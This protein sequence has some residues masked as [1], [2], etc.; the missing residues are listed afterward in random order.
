MSPILKTIS[1]RDKINKITYLWSIVSRRNSKTAEYFSQNKQYSGQ[2]RKEFVQVD[3]RHM[4]KE[5]IINDLYW[6]S[7]LGRS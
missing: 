1:F 5:L 6:L 3:L 7:W 2:K 4:E